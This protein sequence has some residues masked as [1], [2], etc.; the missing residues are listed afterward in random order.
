[1]LGSISGT[2]AA[3]QR[4]EAVRV[5]ARTAKEVFIKDFMGKYSWD[6]ACF[7]FL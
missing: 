4:E 7:G 3:W 1:M 5:T 6:W 2:A